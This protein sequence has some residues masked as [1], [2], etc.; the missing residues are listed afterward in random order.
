MHE[1]VDVRTHSG[2]PT[3]LR[4]CLDA[5]RSFPHPTEKHVALTWRWCR[6]NAACLGVA[7]SRKI[8]FKRPGIAFLMHFHAEIIKSLCSKLTGGPCE[9]GSTC[10]GLPLHDPQLLGALRAATLRP[11][12]S[13]SWCAA[14]R[15]CDSQLVSRPH[16]ARHVALQRSGL[17]ADGSQEGGR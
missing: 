14:L 12:A 16:G 10:C 17:C 1:E 15:S 11:R 6:R 9:A 4:T 8:A 2:P 5:Q 13:G 3:C 7:A